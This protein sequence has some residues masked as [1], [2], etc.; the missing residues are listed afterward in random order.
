MGERPAP[1]PASVRVSRLA[2]RDGTLAEGQRAVPEEA[3]VSLVFDGGSHAVMMA[4]PS[5]LED[6]AVGFSFNEGLIASIDDIVDCE[7]VEHE[8]GIELR[9]WLTGTRAKALA[10]R[11]RHIAGPTG[12]GLC[13]IDSL[14]EA[15][16]PARKVEAP[17]RVTPAEIAMALDALAP[18]Q[19]LGRET[20]AVHAAGFWRRGRGLLMLREDVGRHNALDKLVGAMLRGGEEASDGIVLLTS[21]VSIEMVQK[22]AMLGAPV[23][24]AVSAP[25]ALAIRTAEAANITLVGVARSDGFEVFSHAE[26]IVSEALSHVA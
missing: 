12:C 2:W 21:R 18:A 19:A 17:G 11:R 14:T 20:R 3:A 7:T 5:D 9:L 26:R 22:T 6:F 25:T 23:L 15:V 13:G 24:V 1:S 16:R 10:A 4:S 8:E